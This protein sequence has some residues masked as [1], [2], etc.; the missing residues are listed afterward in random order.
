MNSKISPGFL[1]VIPLS[2]STARVGLFADFDYKELNEI[3]NEFLENNEEL[4]DVKILKK[5]H[6]K[7]PIYDPKKDIVKNRAILI[8]DAA[9]QVKPTTSG[10]LIIGFNCAK[11]AAE[12]VYEAISSQNIDILKNYQKRYRKMYNNELK[13]QLKVQNTYKSLD[14]DNLD[15][16]IL[17]LKE[18]EVGKIVSEYGDLDSQAPLM[19][20]L[21]KSGIIFSVLP[22][23]LSRK[24]FGL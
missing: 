23:L 6:G 21:I 13:M 24:I 16:V 11:I 1:W 14:D 22:K 18:K 8:G 7:I 4:R 12:V 5:Y 3:L 2:E 10:G 15:S 20:K 19:I 9:S 17:K